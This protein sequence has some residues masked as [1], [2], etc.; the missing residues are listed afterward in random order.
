MGLR[1]N[2]FNRL[3]ARGNQNVQLAGVDGLLDEEVRGEDAL[4]L[5][6]W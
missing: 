5:P 4:H 2:D 1:G 6:L 3:R